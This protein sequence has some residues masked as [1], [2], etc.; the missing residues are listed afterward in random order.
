MSAQGLVELMSV[1]LLISDT[2]H[3]NNYRQDWNAAFQDNG[4]TY[5]MYSV[6]QYTLSYTIGGWEG[7]RGLYL[8]IEVEI[9]VR[10]FSVVECPP[11]DF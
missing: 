9:I 6:N 5:R 1:L 11:Q 4:A 3:V 10:C 8:I 7:G 2:L